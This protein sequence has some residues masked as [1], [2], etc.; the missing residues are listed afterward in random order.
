MIILEK[1]QR[2]GD[3]RGARYLSVSMN[4]ILNSIVPDRWLL[5]MMDFR[6]R[7]GWTRWEYGKLTENCRVPL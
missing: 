4:C 7:V 3:E 6:Q 1:K 2:F 5:G